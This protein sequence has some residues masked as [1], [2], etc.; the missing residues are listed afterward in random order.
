[1][2]TWCC[3]AT[4]YALATAVCAQS[5]ALALDNPVKFE[6]R[7]GRLDL[8]ITATTSSVDFGGVTTTGWV[9][10]VC[11]RASRTSTSCL[12]G[13]SAKHYGGVWLHLLPNDTLHIR[14]VNGLPPVP[15]AEHCNPDLVNNP[16]N[17]HTHGLIV[18]PHRSTGD[19][20]PFGDYVFVE[21]RNTHNHA[22]CPPPPPNAAGPASSGHDGAT[23]ADASGGAHPGMDVA[24]N[25]VEY[26]I[27]LVKHPSGVFWFHPHVH[28][29]ALNQVTSGLAGVITVGEPTDA[30]QGDT[31]CRTAIEASKDQLLV[32]KDS[33]VLASGTLLNQQD[34][35]FCTPTA[36]AG[37]PPRQGVCA[38][39]DDPNHK[40]GHWFHTINGQL[41]P[42]VTV[43]GNGAL[44][45]IL[46]AA[47][48]RSYDLSLVADDGE[49]VPLQVI[50]MDGIAIDTTLAAD[51][52]A[53]Q[54][55]IGRKMDVFRCSDV[56]GARY[57]EAVCS[58][59]IRM[60]PSSRV[61]V[62]VLND[63]PGARH[64]VWRTDVY[65]TNGDQWPTIDLASVDLA[66][67]V[68][69]PAPALKIQGA[70]KEVLSP[71]G[72]LGAPA[73]LAQPGADRPA[74]LDQV[75]EQPSAREVILSSPGLRLA[76]QYAIDPALKLG[77]RQDPDCANLAPG[78]HRRIYFGYP[79]PDTFG[80]AASVI[81]ADG[82]EKQLTPV[83]PFDPTKR[84]I[85]LTASGVKGYPTT[86]VWE[87]YNL[88]NE[89]H[90]FHIHQT[91]FWLLSSASAQAGK[92][93]EA[94]VLQDNMP[95]V[96]ATDVTNCN[97][98]LANFQ[99]KACQPEPVW[100]AIPFTQIGDFVFHC[101]ILEHEDGGMMARIG[102][103]APPLVA[104][105]K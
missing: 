40:G 45:R 1:M 49:T 71:E 9:Y 51:L 99:S 66:A 83:S 75:R 70:A 92:I 41:Y 69:G 82:Q 52:P 33:Q 91:R 42:N 25:V 102:V 103:M 55:Q 88:T 74:P 97:G 47:G 8:I 59:H 2:A 90:N 20:D 36:V 12:P 63:Q 3:R 34:S 16:T 62:R 98:T 15:D 60:M 57:G 50:S 84:T 95:L 86:E 37:E 93:D 61:S 76:Q 64:G 30:C 100:A 53:L 67:P 87:I 13:T 35:P 96:H 17:L 43:G 38:G 48:S 101:H 89:D 39:D 44:W 81:G 79:T 68:S 11:R 73:S 19:G 22:Q 4:M 32:L 31:Q 105:K 5:T 26:A 27:H 77:L 65:D 7:D 18:E 29:L 58:R 21:V 80:I 28:G 85:C 78:E 10:D 6:S 72:V 54:A 104:E 46:N 56:P 94:A 24:D 14:L 23:H